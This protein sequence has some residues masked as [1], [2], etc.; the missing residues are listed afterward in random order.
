MTVNPASPLMAAILFRIPA[1]ENGTI[2]EVNGKTEPKSFAGTFTQVKRTWHPGDVIEIK[3]PF[4]P[5]ASRWFNG[6]VAFER[7][8]LVFSYPIGESWVKLADRGLTA[9]WQVFPKSAWNYGVAVDPENVANVVS[10][11]ESPITEMAFTARPAP[12]TLTAKARQ[13]PLWRAED[14]AANPMPASPVPSNEP[15]ENITLV[16]YAAAKLRI[17]AFPRLSEH[18]P[19]KSS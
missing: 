12:V 8:P 16:P 1:G 17:T 11:A 3:F 4:K 2:I 19:S 18:S 10:V 9:D 7:G 6:A 5:R 15:Q 14:G 13:I